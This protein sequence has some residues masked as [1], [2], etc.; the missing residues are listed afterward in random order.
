MSRLSVQGVFTELC[1]MA[2]HKCI[3][4]KIKPRFLDVV[5]EVTVP[6]VDI[7]IGMNTKFLFAQ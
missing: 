5:Q 1:G 6:G 7:P 3:S 4:I 2:V